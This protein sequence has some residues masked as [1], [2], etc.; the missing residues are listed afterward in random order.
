MSGAATTRDRRRRIRPLSRA[1]TGSLAIA[2][3][4]VVVFAW[5]VP[6]PREPLFLLWVA[7]CTSVI[8]PF[9]VSR[10]VA[11]MPDL[12]PA[13]RRFWRTVA[14]CLL[15]AGAGVLA[16]GY[17][18]LSAGA[19][20][21]HMSIVT[22]SL[23]GATMGLLLWSLIRLP[24]GA[25]GRG[26]VLR[27]ALDAG[28]VLIAGAAFLWH[29]EA[30]PA[31]E[32]AG[33]RPATLLAMTVTLLLELVTVFALIK[34]AL[35][36]QAHVARGA[37]RLLAAAL[38]VGAL[39]SLLQGLVQSRPHLDMVQLTL[40][41]IVVCVTAAAQ[42]QRTE[43]T[44][45]TP[46]GKATGRPFS[47]LAY[48]AVAAIDVLLLIS[49]WS[50]SDTVATA[51]AVVALTALVMWRQ[52][53]AFR[54]NTDLLARL[55]HS[56]THDPL[57]QLP[58][59]ALFTARLTTALAGHPAGR[60]IGVALIDLDDFK[61][62]NDTLGH[63][64]G[65]VLLVAVAQR[66]LACV[67]PGDTAARLG[68]DEFVVLLEDVTPDEADQVTRR[69][70]DV[71]TEPVVAEGHHLLVRASIGLADGHAGDEAGELLRRAD[72]AMYAGKHGGGS[73]VQRYRPGMSGTVAGS[74]ALGAELQQAIAGQQMFLEYQPIVSLADGRTAGVEALIRWSHPA[75]GTV[76][77]AE[78]IPVAERTG[79][80]VALGGWALHEACRQFAAWW[81][82]HGAAA[83]A[84]LNVNVSPR[85]LSDAG[86]VDQVAAALADTGVPA[87]RLTLEITES[88][89]VDVAEAA[90]QLRALRGLGVRIALDDFGTGQSS[91]TL[92]H[93][94]PVD[95][96][97]LD[98]SFL[99]PGGAGAEVSM[100]AAVLAL[101][102][103]AHLEIVAEGVET[104]EQAAAL[105]RCGYRWAQGFH[106]ARP[107]P[108]DE[109]GRRLARPAPGEPAVTARVP[110]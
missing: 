66:L 98:R 92:L 71:L 85:Q 63:R 102:H 65:D 14:T 39:S 1:V 107:A 24:M 73:R 44:R 59:R 76:S 62:V 17:D 48:L 2:V 87:H 105:A 84:E 10:Q 33:Y 75:R 23:Y 96:L 94:L 106:F 100:P 27:I 37:L 9:V 36:G 42:W 20:G 78:F 3:V 67:R 81:Q 93:E 74:A 52:M 89:A 25:S 86:F 82:E 38:L 97:K 53:T 69:M 34:V 56:A 60:G 7:P 99:R 80:I 64:A 31:L 35:A 43:V 28:T 8:I 72:I 57:T 40:P 45:R 109:F 26:D 49:T 51:I 32:T 41:A 21:R 101:A 103:A 55:D 11:R 46:G 70:L 58:N 19:A 29:Y 90:A 6:T 54:E 50:G 18:S 95:Q 77:P 88:A 83:P 108:A 5:N 79:L 16:H 30:R 61:V 104:A 110:R 15:M 12:P 68:G 91:L 22:V 13:T 47:R 4:A